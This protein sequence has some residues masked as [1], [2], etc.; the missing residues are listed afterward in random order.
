MRD[1][2]NFFSGSGAKENAGFARRAS[3]KDPKKPVRVAFFSDI[4]ENVSKNLI[5]TNAQYAD[6]KNEVMGSIEPYGTKDKIVLTVYEREASSEFGRESAI[7]GFK[8]YVKGCTEALNRTIGTKI[9]LF[10][11]FFLLGVGMEVALFAIPGA[12]DVV[13]AW[14]AECLKIIANVFIW[15]LGGFLAFDFPG[16]VHTLSKYRQIVNNIEF[17][18]KRFE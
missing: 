12:L 9:I 11:I 15:Q 6:L 16:N 5:A 18:F 2:R 14:L 1:Y 10:G 13:P 3:R 4:F 17:E 7:I 8:K